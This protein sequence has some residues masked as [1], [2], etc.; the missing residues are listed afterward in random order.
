MNPP[1]GSLIINYWKTQKKKFTTGNKLHKILPYLHV[2]SLADQ[3]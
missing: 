1:I 2:L 3:P